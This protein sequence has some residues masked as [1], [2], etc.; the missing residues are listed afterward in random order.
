MQLQS[1]DGAWQLSVAGPLEE[2]AGTSLPNAILKPPPEAKLQGQELLQGRPGCLPAAPA[3]P[4]HLLNLYQNHLQFLFK[5]K[6]TLFGQK[7]GQ[8]HFAEVLRTIFP[9]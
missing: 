3:A 5:L 2:P 4:P 9:K 6:T 7:L 1:I 8:D